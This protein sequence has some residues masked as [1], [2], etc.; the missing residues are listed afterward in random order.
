MISKGYLL[1]SNLSLAEDY[2]FRRSVILIC[3]IENNKNP[4]GFILNK[5]LEINLTNILS[6]VNKKFKIFYGGPVSTDTLFCVHKSELNLKS[7]KEITKNISYGFDLDEIILKTESGE[8]DEKNIM[9]FLG[10]SGWSDKQLLNE[11]K[12][13]F[14]KINKDYSKKIFEKT[15]E[16][17]WNTLIKKMEG[18]SYIWSNAPENIQYN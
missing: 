15:Q 3:D 16:N 1:I 2:V 10:Y 12:E 7:S 11:I 6:N 5:P 4:M 18:D 17:L 13:N 9:F 8:L 14:W